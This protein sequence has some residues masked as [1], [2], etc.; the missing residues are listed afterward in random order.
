[1]EC[2]Q[3]ER[4]ERNES[5]KESFADSLVAYGGI[6]MDEKK[7]RPLYPSLKQDSRMNLFEE[8]E[9]DTWSGGHFHHFR[10]NGQNGNLVTFKDLNTR[11]I[12]P[13]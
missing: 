1:M 13:C 4:Q 10:D 7:E 9:N 3:I 11:R 2:E 12:I 6:N 5:E 8:G